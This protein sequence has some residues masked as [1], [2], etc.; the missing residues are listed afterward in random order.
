MSKLVR[1]C[2]VVAV[3]GCLCVEQPAA[4][5]ER[6]AGP[7]VDVEWLSRNLTNPDVVILDASPG[8]LYAA[9]HVPGALGVDFLTYGFP[10]KPLSEMERRYQSWGLSPGKKVVMYDQGGTFM[11]TRLFFALYYHGYPAQDL[12]VLDGGL[13]KWQERGLPVTKTRHLR[14]EPAR[15]RSRASGKT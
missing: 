10:E 6:A 5:A 8:Q 7:L 13:A 1:C 15:S 3:V 12:F 11:A 14:Q 9:K 4:A 2:L